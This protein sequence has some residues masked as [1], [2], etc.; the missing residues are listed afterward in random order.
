[1]E[2]MTLSQILLGLVVVI[3]IGIVVL[4]LGRRP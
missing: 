4:I 3:L 2:T 1:V